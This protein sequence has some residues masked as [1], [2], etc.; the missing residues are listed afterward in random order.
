MP[1]GYYPSHWLLVE[2]LKPE[3]VIVGQAFSNTPNVDATFE[4]ENGQ[5]SELGTTLIAADGTIKANAGISRTLNL[6][7]KTTWGTESGVGDHFYRTKFNM[8]KYQATCHNTYTLEIIK[9]NVMQIRAV[10]QYGGAETT[11]STNR[12]N[13]KNCAPCKINGG[14]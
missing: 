7:A 13:A 14:A 5:E 6:S 8:K 11:P 9:T 1:I 2:T 12:F 3:W 4:Y 10:S